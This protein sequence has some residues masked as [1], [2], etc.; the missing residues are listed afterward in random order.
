MDAVALSPVQARLL[1]EALAIG[2]LVG[3]ERYKMRD[4][5]ERST[6]GV[7]TFAI[8]SLLGGI[9]GLLGNVTFTLA[10]FGAVA[11]L[12]AIGYYR[13]SSRHLGLTTETA[14]FVVFWL[15]YLVHT[16][17]FLAIA[18]AIVLTIMLASKQ[19][20]HRF[21]SETMSERE[22]FDTLKFLAV[23]LVVYPLLPDRAVDPLGIFNPA[24]T[25][26]LIALVSTIAYVGSLLARLFVPQRGLWLSALLGG[27]VSTTATTIALA[28]RASE[29]SDLSRLV[30]P[31]AVGA[32][33][34]QFPRLLLLVAVLDLSLAR[35][36]APPLL[37]MTAVGFLFSAV[38]ARRGN[39]EPELPPIALPIRN[40]F[41]VMP[42]LKFGALF[43]VVLFVVR[44][45]EEWS[46]EGGTYM[47]SAVGGML[48]SSA[49]ALSLA[50]LTANEAISSSTFTFA[51]L[52]G[53]ATNALVKWTLAWTQGTRRLA[54]W[55]GAGFVV[56]IAT[57]F[58]VALLQP[59]L[60][61][62]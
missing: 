28:N 45:A 48:S 24:K 6:A 58:V 34:I 23:I 38:L 60:P 17:E 49:V 62:P 30:V 59:A 51:L 32:N 21:V 27:I 8:F 33:A 57:G 54:V 19:S 20:M 12:V 41:S 11:V 13:E 46:G 2:L 22:L 9:C 35:S 55:L 53:I 10:A 1:A 14:A 26:L 15:G 18:T 3:I 44:L 47:A 4:P 42:A 37:A 56:A 5:G 39:D 31:A 29:E 36:L 61:T 16:Q 43:V 40:P 7:R 52:V 25:W 50:D